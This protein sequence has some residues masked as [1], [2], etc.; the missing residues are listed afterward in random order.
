MLAMAICSQALA[1]AFGDTTSMRRQGNVAV[2][3]YV[4]LKKLEMWCN[5]VPIVSRKYGGVGIAGK[6]L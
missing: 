5:H 2:F 4:L 1:L 3:P 6:L